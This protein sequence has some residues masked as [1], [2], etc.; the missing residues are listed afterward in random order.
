MATGVVAW[1][2]VQPAIPWMW[3]WAPLVPAALLLFL[4]TWSVVV[5]VDPQEL[6]VRRTPGKRLTVPLGSVRKVEVLAGRRKE[7]KP[8]SGAL[9]FQVRHGPGVALGLDDGRRVWVACDYPQLLANA[10]DALQRG[11]APERGGSDPAP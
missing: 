3:A 10:I 4:S 11:I 5:E 2:A 8:P 7:I 9:R 1:L 6:R